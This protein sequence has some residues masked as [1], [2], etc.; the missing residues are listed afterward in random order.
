MSI[1]ISGNTYNIDNLL[2]DLENIKENNTYRNKILDG[3]K[4][5]QYFQRPLQENFP[6]ITGY[7]KAIIC[8][9]MNHH[10]PPLNRLKNIQREM[11]EYLEY[12]R[13]NYKKLVPTLPSML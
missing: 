6:N 11:S 12:I 5:I 1:E 8:S 2:N 4:I 3:C 13:D 7:F 10:L 9:C